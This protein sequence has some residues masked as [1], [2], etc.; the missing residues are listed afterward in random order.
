MIYIFVT[1]AVIIA[2]HI[3]YAI[4][5][6]MAVNSA[7][8]SKDAARKIISGD[9]SRILMKEVLILFGIIISSVVL[10]GPMWGDRMKQSDNEGTDV[11][12][13]LDVSMSML[14]KDGGAT[15][16]ERAKSAIR[17]IAGSLKGDR[18]GLIIFAGEAFVQCP[19]TND[20]GAFTMFLE[21]V[22]TD[23]I[24]VQGTDMGRM[25]SAA[26]KVY[27][28]K[29]LTSKMLIVIT[30]GEDHENKIDAEAEKFKEIGIAVYALGI[31]KSGDLIPFAKN[32]DEENFYR[33]RSGSLIKTSQNKDLLK[34]LADKTGGFYSDITSS[35]S[36]INKIISII[37]GKDKI[38]YG[39]KMVK[40]KIDRTYIFLLILIIILG[41]EM[42]INE[43]KISSIENK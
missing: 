5:R 40:E 3:F 42:F 20:M 33:D 36:G 43:R 19:L 27:T 9:Y 18:I 32:S 10:L 2:L 13:A 7:F 23:S 25:L 28:K 21:S 35:F 24:N 17:L 16:L 29:N 34:E 12:I 6:R 4:W 39:S 41:A 14:A 11:L 22:T 15:R 37:E 1:G 30:D 31:G 26:E 8:G 38:Y